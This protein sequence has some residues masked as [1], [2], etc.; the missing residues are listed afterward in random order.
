MTG[1][2]ADKNNTRMPRALNEQGESMAGMQERENEAPF[3]RRITTPV[4]PAEDVEEKADKPGRGGRPKLTAEDV[5]ARFTVRREERRARKAEKPPREMGKLVRVV[6]ASGLGLG[7]IA[8][9][10]GL[11]AAEAQFR[12]ETS[13]ND[14]KIASLMGAI[15]AVVPEE[16]GEA[17]RGLSEG[18]AAA[19]KRS[20][21]LAAAE[22]RF[23]QI[24]WEGNRDS[25]TDD[26]RPAG[27]VLRALEH[28][29]EMAAFFEPASFVLTDEQAYS[30]RTEDLTG[31]G[32]IDPRQP[33]FSAYETPPKAGGGP[34]AASPESY[35]WKTVS[36]APSGTPG[37]FSVVWANTDTGTGELL[38]W[39]TARYSVES[40]AFN[41]LAVHRTTQGDSR[42][43]RAE[44][45]ATDETK[46]VKA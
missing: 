17:V 43:L 25:R 31:P 5:E 41:T 12:A 30:F 11:N 38:A 28:R 26:G 27:A 35:V 21:D 44:T 33:W 34:T 20:N 15:S 16:G 32:K 10:M 13:S 1:G 3:V 37:V 6:V 19:Q 8:L 39:A 18:L 36:V 9:G 23:A 29:R 45:T 7:I 14:S 42:Q 2:T 4:E 46:G 24:A 40:D 22:Q